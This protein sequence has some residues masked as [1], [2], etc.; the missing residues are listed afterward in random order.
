MKNFAFIFCLLFS[1]LLNA[2]NINTK[3]DYIIDKDAKVR[4]SA[5]ELITREITIDINT[6]PGI[7]LYQEN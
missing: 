1:S 3:Q 7:V 4:E 2:E 5:D 6:H